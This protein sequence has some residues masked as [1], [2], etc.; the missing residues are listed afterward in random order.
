MIMSEL[1]KLLQ[2]LNF[3]LSVCL[4]DIPKCKM[5]KGKNGK[6]YVNLT[7]SKRREPDQWKRDLKVYVSQ[8]KAER[9]AGQAKVYVGAGK[10]VQFDAKQGEEPSDA[11][12]SA[13][14]NTEETDEESPF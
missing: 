11:D 10:T 2:N 3:E 4:S 14:L 5:S 6:I 8:L 7:V 9:E 13:L 12:V 1:E